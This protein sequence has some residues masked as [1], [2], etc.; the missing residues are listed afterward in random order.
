MPENPDSSVR[1]L[2]K[3]LQGIETILVYLS[4]K[5]KKLSS[6]RSIS[7]HTDLSMRVAKNIL[8]QLE[9]FN[10]V[11]RVV[12][13][14]NILP[15]W[16]ITKFGKKVLKEAEGIEKTI[17]F[18]SKKEEL[19]HKISIPEELEELEAKIRTTQD[20][21]TD[22]L[23]EIQ[24]ELS[25][26]LG[27]VM[28]LDKPVFEDLLSLILRRIKSLKQKV[29]NLPRDPTAAFALTKIGEKKK[30]LSKSEAKQLLSEIY[31]F[32]AL[33]LNELHRV[34]DFNERLSNQIE[35]EEIANG[36]SLAQDLRE[37][38]RVLAN[39]IHARESIRLNSHVLSEEQLK[40]LMKDKITPDLLHGIIEFPA[41]GP[42]QS[43]KLQD[44]VL[45]MHSQLANETNGIRNGYS[46]IKDSIPLYSLYHLIADEEPNI[47]FTIEELEKTIESLADEG[48]IPGLKIIQAD[49]D[50]YLKIVQLKARDISKDELE[51]IGH[52]LEM[53]KFNLS[54]MVG[55]TGW[56]TTQVRTLLDNLTEMGILKFSESLL[57][58]QRW[59][60]VSDQIS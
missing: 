24:R 4:G 13:K 58:G 25:K 22:Q 49:E 35:K 37:E 23:N 20:N 34:Q 43:K 48:H 6:I 19:V 56:S 30:K 36:F 60:I 46:Q 9:K 54:D 18:P 57:H 31:F 51:L 2:P 21:I 39:I 26:V 53:Q 5:G 12:E 33:I 16:R 42:K 8:L 38:L 47:H 59:Y 3:S 14:N 41:G 28:N 11:E 55:K 32:N 17:E 52:A 7:K 29:I 50:H 1:E 15:K 45:K 10:Q 27:P 40:N 44:V